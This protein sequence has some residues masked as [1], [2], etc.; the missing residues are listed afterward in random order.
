[1]EAKCLDFCK[2][3]VNILLSIQS[4]DWF[5]FHTLTVSNPAL[6]KI[7]ERKIKVML[8]KTL[9]KY[10]KWK[11]FIFVV[12]KYSMKG[13]QCLGALENMKSRER[14]GTQSNGW[15]GAW[16]PETE[17]W[18]QVPFIT[19]R[20][21]CPHSECVSTAFSVFLLFRIL[22]TDKMVRCACLGRQRI[23]FCN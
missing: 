8:L 9:E 7:K 13:R 15:C 20:A 5:I 1:M 4:C 18:S 22:K 3:H 16:G 11:L 12:I 14:Q 2:S 6:S 23:M 19:I 17:V 21:V 10:S